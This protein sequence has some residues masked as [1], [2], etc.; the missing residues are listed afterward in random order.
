MKAETL[1][2]T[3]SP[4]PP[5]SLSETHELTD[6]TPAGIEDQLYNSYLSGAMSFDELM[7]ELHA[8]TNLDKASSSS[9]KSTRRRSR[10]PLRAKRAKSGSEFEDLLSEPGKSSLISALGSIVGGV[11]MFFLFI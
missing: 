3:L 4:N 5:T 9:K 11:S 10:P 8:E 2:G 7:K 6:S 1:N